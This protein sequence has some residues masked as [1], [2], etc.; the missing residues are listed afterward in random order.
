MVTAAVGAI[1]RR[2]V[3]CFFAIVYALAGLA[4][5]VIGLPHLSG[6]SH[7]GGSASALAVFPVMVVG[8]GLAGV[9]VTAATGGRPALRE[10][11]ARWQR[12]VRHRWYLV[13]LVPPI[14]ILAVLGLLHVFVSPKFTPQLFLFGIAAGVFAGFCEEFGWTGFA[15]PRMSSRLGAL[16]GALLLGL[17]WGLWHF[18]VVDS[19]GAASPHGRYFLEFFAAFVAMLVALRA[20]IAWLYTNTGS[21]RLAQS[22]HASSTGFLVVLG[23]GG[24]SAGQEVLW[25]AG[26]AAV[27]W[28]V[29]GVVVALCG[30]TLVVRRRAATANRPEA[31]SA[32]ITP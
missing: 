16:R 30:R 2:P 6:G 7:R 13:V 11:W 24:V 5:A 4:L 3:L 22:L 28:L 18:P 23:A 21:I 14:C 32:T 26:Y 29:V 9:G 20:L 31:T 12:P 27:L 8:V 10:L 25:Y 19:L 1:Q 17:L 15:Y